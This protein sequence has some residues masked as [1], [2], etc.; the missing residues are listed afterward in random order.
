MRKTIRKLLWAVLFILTG[1]VILMSNYG[2]LGF[3]V[4][5]SRDWPIILIAWGLLKLVDV[6][7]G[8]DKGSC[9]D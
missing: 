3:H 2:L 4:D 6:I 9:K 1:G 8:G 7:I 5:L